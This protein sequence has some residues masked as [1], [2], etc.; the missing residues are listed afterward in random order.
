MKYS[1]ESPEYITEYLCWPQN[2]PRTCSKCGNH[3]VYSYADNGKKVYTLDGLVYQIIH[4]YSC[5]N[6]ICSLYKKYRNPAPRRDYGRSYYGKDVLNKVAREIFVFEQSPEQIHKR[7]TLDYSLKISL[8][9][10]QRMYQEILLVKSHDIDKTTRKIVQDNKKVLI[11]LDGQKP[12]QGYPAIWLFTDII[13]GRLLR[14]VVSASM[15]NGK[16]YNEIAQI[17]D[18]F[19]VKSVGFVSDK[20]NNIVKCLQTYYPDIPHQYCTLHFVQHL[21]SHLL[22]ADNH[23]FHRLTDIITHLY[24]LTKSNDHPV[25]FEQFGTLSVSTVFSS[26]IS[27]LKK[28]CKIK[29]KKFKFLRG[30]WLFRA[31]QTF[32]DELISYISAMGSNLRIEKLC[33]KL[34]T[35]LSDVLTENRIYFFDNLF[36]F[37]SF[38][39]IYQRLYSNLPNRAS[40]QTQL[41]NI[42]GKLWGIAQ[43]RNPDLRLDTLKNIKP[44]GYNSFS[45]ILAEWV[46]LWN[47]YLSG[48]FNYYDFPVDIRTNALQEQAFSQEKAKISRR[49]RMKNI[50][51]FIQTRGELYLRLVY[52][53]SDELENDLVDSYTADLIKS[54]KTEFQKKITKVTETWV[55]KDL[56]IQGIKETLQK[57]HPNFRKITI[58]KKLKKA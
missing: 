57:Y 42:F 39:L 14:T 12:Q 11:A 55:P 51:F 30:L 48:L 13:S 22:I 31:L 8:R 26:M 52:A 40:R 1:A 47:S 25:H 46:R 45:T 17:L 54:L 33:R 41:D 35:K 36:L 15:P 43:N 10:I 58:K 34:H 9:T 6:P 20:Q 37:D 24:I 29:T 4:Y 27:D 16:L 38:R 7:L 5:I 23:L 21:W 50:G 44:T 53:N 18:D 3:L 49:L 28:M 2:V 19:N 32:S 56:Q